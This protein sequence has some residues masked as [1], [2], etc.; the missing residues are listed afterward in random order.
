MECSGLV[1]SNSIWKNQLLSILKGAFH[2]KFNALRC[3]WNFPYGASF[4]SYRRKTE[5]FPRKRK[6]S[7]SSRKGKLIE[8]PSSRANYLTIMTSERRVKLC[9]YQ[10]G[11]ISWII[12]ATHWLSLRHWPYPNGPEP[13][14]WQP[15]IFN[16][17]LQFLNAKE[18]G[19][20]KIEWT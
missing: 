7:I 10:P 2:S 1:L 16:L 12:I 9:R 5:K 11:P 13:R 14:T 20:L 4:S 19:I 17:V 6:I 8:K 3:E 18:W 15:S